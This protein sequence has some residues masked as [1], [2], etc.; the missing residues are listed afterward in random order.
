[1]EKRPAHAFRRYNLKRW[2]RVVAN[3]LGGRMAVLVRV[4]LLTVAATLGLASASA[5]CDCAMQPI[6]ATFWSADEVFVGVAEVTTLH[7][8]AR[9]IR[10]QRVTFTIEESFKG[11]E[12]VGVEIL[13]E[14]FGVSCDYEFR[15]GVRYLVLAWRD[16]DGWLSRTRGPA[17]VGDAFRCEHSPRTRTSRRG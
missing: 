14:G 6:C 2:V 3:V 13:S 16:P 11:N 10:S 17:P 5:A 8:D 4:G 15:D 7:A 12:T 9:R 1:V